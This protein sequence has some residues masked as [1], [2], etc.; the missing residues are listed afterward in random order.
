MQVS[1]E[2]DKKQSWRAFVLVPNRDEMLYIS[3][4]QDDY[5]MGDS[6]GKILMQLFTNMTTKASDILTSL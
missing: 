2:H 5:T 4:E 3:Q 1:P 6:S